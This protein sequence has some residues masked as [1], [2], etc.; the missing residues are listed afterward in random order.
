M[1]RLVIDE[2]RCKGCALCTIACP[3]GLIRLNST[4]NKH[5]FLPAHITAKDLAK[6]SSCT[7]CAQMCPDVAISVFR[8]TKPEQQ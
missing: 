6:C 3:K 7:L 5:G 2:A 4:I 1:P 8:E